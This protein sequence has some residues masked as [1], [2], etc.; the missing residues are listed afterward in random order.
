MADESDH[1]RLVLIE[2]RLNEMNEKLDDQA[3][4]T[5]ELVDTWRSAKT[6]IAFVQLAAKVGAALAALW[7]MGK[8]LLQIGEIK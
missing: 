2:N 1:V 4:A 3:Q 5:R 7:L 6:L 8:G